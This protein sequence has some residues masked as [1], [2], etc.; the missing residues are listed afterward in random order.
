MRDYQQRVI[1]EKAALDDK[2]DRLSAFFPIDAF[3]QLSI[4]DQVDLR[5]QA[6]LMEGYSRILAKR[7]ARFT[8]T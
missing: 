1:D 3:E 4:E 7:I 5:I 2:R 6:F 8:A